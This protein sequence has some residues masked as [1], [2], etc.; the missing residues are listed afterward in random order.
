MSHLC[1]LCPSLSRTLHPPHTATTNTQP[2]HKHSNNSK[3]YVNSDELMDFLK[4]TV[5]K[6]PDLPPEGEPEVPKAKRQRCVRVVHPKH[7]VLGCV[8]VCVQW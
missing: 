3:A 8:G 7:C 5:D 4:D 1:P 2:P 6:A